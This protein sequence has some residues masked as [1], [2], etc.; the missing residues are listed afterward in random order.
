MTHFVAYN[1]HVGGESKRLT[2]LEGYHREPLINV[3]TAV[4]GL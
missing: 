4:A 2:I 3:V 1:V